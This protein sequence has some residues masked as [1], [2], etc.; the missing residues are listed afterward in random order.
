MRTIHTIELRPVDTLMPSPHNAR[1]HSAKQVR[2]IAKSIEE[3]GFVSPILVDEE[4]IIIAGHGRQQAAIGLKMAVVPAIQ[5]DGLTAVQKRKLMLADNRISMNAGWDRARL[6]LELK[7]LTIEGEDITIT[8]FEAAE[9]DQIILDHEESSNDPADATP[10]RPVGPAVTKRGDLWVLDGHR[11]L[12]GDAR[13][14]GDV[15][16]L[17]ADV[18][19]AMM[20]TDPPYNLRIGD[21]VGRGKRK[22][23]EFQMASGEMTTAEFTSF[24]EETLINAVSQS[25]AG[26]VHFVFIDWRNIDTLLA[27]C[28]R[29]YG[30]VL[31]V[32]VWVKS[33]GGQG[34]FYRS[35]HEFV[36]IVR[37]GNA[38]HRNNIDLG[39]H[40][41]NR[42]NVW[43][44]AGVNS[45]RKGRLDELTVH[46]TVKPVALIVEAIK[47]C[48]RRGDAVLDIF[49]GSGSTLLACEKIGRRAFLLEIEPTYVDVT[50]SRWQ[51]FTG[52]D[53]I[54][55]ASGKTFDTL[56][57]EGAPTPID[58][59]D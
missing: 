36:V 41:R 34:S 17:C 12:C 47:D 5:I 14:D 35:Q 37:V 25:P 55:A 6:A 49:G 1:T 23:A 32:A 2:Q 15:T 9:I 51:E 20:I 21:L 46:P 11:L 26:A 48:T 54:H 18:Q 3:F 29:L 57:A 43:H 42:T 53:A 45:F 27:I 39:R 40:G 31:N 24:L 10:S 58:E 56:C 30:A 19:P 28:R 33:N 4:G 50:I 52:K 44:F 59:R 13:D 22:H 38:P 16:R 7:E 8:G